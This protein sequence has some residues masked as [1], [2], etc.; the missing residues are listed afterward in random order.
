M[1]LGTYLTI[2]NPKLQPKNP[3]SVYIISPN[4]Y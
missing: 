3:V 2:N 4:H 1:I